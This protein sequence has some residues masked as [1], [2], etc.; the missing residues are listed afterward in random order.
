MPPARPRAAACGSPC[1]G[2]GRS[3]PPSKVMPNPASKDGDLRAGPV[4]HRAGSRRFSFQAVRHAR[5]R[6]RRHR[7]IL[8][9][10][11]SR[12]PGS[13]LQ[14]PAEGLKRVLGK[15]AGRAPVRRRRKP[16]EKR[17]GTGHGLQHRFEDFRR[18]LYV[19]GAAT[20]HAALPRLL[21]TALRGYVKAE[22]VAAHD[23]VVAAP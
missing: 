11:S 17:K 13:Y 21:E 23:G 19:R 18:E 3:G 2:T 6:C 16:A 22:Q 1:R 14:R 7:V 8:T 10:V 15:L 12:Q 9:S 5:S 4:R 20:E